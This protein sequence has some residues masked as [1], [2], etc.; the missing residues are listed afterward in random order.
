[1]KKIK[2]ILKKYPYDGNQKAAE[3]EIKKFM[4]ENK[5]KKEF[6]LHIEPLVQYEVKNII[7]NHFNVGFNG[8]V[9][10]LIVDEVA[11]G[12]AG[13]LKDAFG[14]SDEHMAS[15]SAQADSKYQE[16]IDTISPSLQNKMSLNLA[17][18]QTVDMLVGLSLRKIKGHAVDLPH[19]KE[20]VTINS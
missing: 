20:E 15:L 14:L 19:L 2:E 18:A 4:D 3:D 1:M 7:A 11:N 17:N 9:I 8:N 16:W 10:D 5:Q 13:K 6:N 12:D